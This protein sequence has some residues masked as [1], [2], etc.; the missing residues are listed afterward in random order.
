MD[1]EQSTHRD[2]LQKR[3]KDHGWA[4]GPHHG[5]GLHRRGDLRL[6]DGGHRRDVQHRRGGLRR[7]GHFRPPVGADSR[8]RSRGANRR[9]RLTREF[10]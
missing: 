10:S 8:L 4:G 6:P 5:G 1:P 2:R 7:G 9:N 3:V